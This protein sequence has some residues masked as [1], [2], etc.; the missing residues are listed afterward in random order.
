MD[1]LHLSTQPVPAL[2]A[3]VSLMVVIQVTATLL[4]KDLKRQLFP[5][6]VMREVTD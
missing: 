5:L 6:Q 3:L 2:S 1:F 4:I